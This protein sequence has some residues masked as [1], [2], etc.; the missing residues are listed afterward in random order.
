MSWDY[1]VWVAAL[2][3]LPVSAEAATQTRPAAVRAVSA[4]AFLNSLGVNTHVDQGYDP[5][6]YIGPL[7]YLGLR[8]VRDGDRHVD[9]E[10]AIARATGVRFVI[11][12]AGDLQGLIASATVLA[13]AGALLAV[14]GPNE[15]NNFPITYNGEKGGGAGQS[16]PPI[17][18]SASRKPGPKPTMSAFNSGRSPR[19]PAPCFRPAPISPIW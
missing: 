3:I 10:V 19:A 15:P 7:R 16:W 14:E 1:L 17:S 9:G 8:E 12:G 4:D 2:L 13:K 11:N 6:S 18:F 5:K